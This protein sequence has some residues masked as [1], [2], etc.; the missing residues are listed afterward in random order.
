MLPLSALM[1][2]VQIPYSAGSSVRQQMT[3]AI[4]FPTEYVTNCVEND[5]VTITNLCVVM[6]VSGHVT[7]SPVY[8]KHGH[9]WLN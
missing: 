6:S 2:L 8:L 4:T 5:E 3:T 9:D 1:A 7:V